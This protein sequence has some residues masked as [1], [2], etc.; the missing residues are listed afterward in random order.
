[1]SLPD[2]GTDEAVDQG[3]TCQYRDGEPSD[4]DRWPDWLI[5]GCP[6]HGAEGLDAS[7]YG[8]FCRDVL[9]DG[10]ERLG[11]RYDELAMFIMGVQQ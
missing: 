5:C 3:C 6:V 4:N 1:M 8:L 2:P 11:V 10:S 9:E 7:D